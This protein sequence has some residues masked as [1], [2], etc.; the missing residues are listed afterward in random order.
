MQ[1]AR[2]VFIQQAFERTLSKWRCD[3]PLRRN[4]E[5][6]DVD[7]GIRQLSGDAESHR[8]RADH[9]GFFDFV[10]ASFV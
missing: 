8:A 9:G 7:A 3:C 5:Q 1:Q 2:L 4:I 6:D 10:H